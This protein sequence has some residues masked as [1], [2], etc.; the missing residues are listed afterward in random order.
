[1]AH[2]INWL[3]HSFINWVNFSSISRK[4]EP[5]VLYYLVVLVYMI[6]MWRK[7]SGHRSWQID[8]CNQWNK[9][10]Y[11]VVRKYPAQYLIVVLRQDPGASQSNCNLYPWPSCN[12]MFVILAPHS[13]HPKCWL[14]S[15]SKIS[16][17]N[18]NNWFS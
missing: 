13:Y 10:K 17:F 12:V 5:G 3:I 7:R 9:Q 8:K 11:W 16:S 1:M 2:L 4:C 6:A 14:L 18:I 15:D